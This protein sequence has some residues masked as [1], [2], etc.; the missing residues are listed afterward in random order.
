MILD[1]RG[2]RF[3]HVQSTQGCRSTIDVMRQGCGCNTCVCVCVCVCTRA[4]CDPPRENEYVLDP[5]EM[6]ASTAIQSVLRRPTASS[7]NEFDNVMKTWSDVLLEI[8]VLCHHY[9]FSCICA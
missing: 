5:S 4:H 3:A 6:N 9:E 2:E 8:K 1:L 7:A